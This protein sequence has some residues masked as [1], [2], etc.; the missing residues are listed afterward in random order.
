MRG[1][2]KQKTKL[3]VSKIAGVSTGALPKQ[4]QL[5]CVHT[6]QNLSR[7]KEKSPFNFC[8]N[9]EQMPPKKFLI[10]IKIKA[11]SIPP[12]PHPPHPTLLRWWPAVRSLLGAGK[13]PGIQGKELLT[14]GILI[15]LQF[16]HLFSCLFRL[17]L[18]CSGA[19]T[20]S[21]LDAHSVIRTTNLSA[22]L[23]L[24][25]AN[26]SQLIN[27]GEY[28]ERLDAKWQKAGSGSE[29]VF[30]VFVEGSRYRA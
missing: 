16:T 7:E 29:V 22:S 3:T 18:K 23:D 5:L 17:D 8:R 4:T 15:I 24:A 25:A 27:D 2:S 26:V 6:R 21:H 12:P 28:L 10:G 30:D 14:C 13:L 19:G 9:A 11:E 1:S 20:V